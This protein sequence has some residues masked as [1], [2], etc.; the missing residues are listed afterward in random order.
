MLACG[1]GERAGEDA[2][3][4]HAPVLA[5]EWPIERRL[6]AEL[7]EA[8]GRDQGPLRVQVDVGD[9]VVIE[10]VQVARRWPELERRIAG[11][12]RRHHLGGGAGGGSGGSGGRRKGLET[13]GWLPGL[14]P[15]EMDERPEANERDAPVVGPREEH[16]LAD[17]RCT[18]EQPARLGIERSD[19]LRAHATPQSREGVVVWNLHEEPHADAC[20][21]EEKRAASRVSDVGDVHPT[22]F[23]A[24]GP[25]P[26]PTRAHAVPGAVADATPCLEPS[27]PTDRS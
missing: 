22:S 15:L 16:A 4:D 9:E 11:R 10:V 8:V 7:G 13:M 14:E 1:S 24:G 21:V 12:T 23:R 3:R 5:G 17:L 18:C 6:R 25:A 27:R 20:L 2:A 26:A 19:E